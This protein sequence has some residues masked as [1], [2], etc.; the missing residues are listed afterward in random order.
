MPAMTSRNRLLPA[1]AITIGGILTAGAVTAMA[2]TLTAFRA[3]PQERRRAMPGDAIV[4]EEMYVTTQAATIAALPERVWP[5]LAQ[6]GADRGGWYSYD[7]VDNDGQPSARAILPEYQ[8][9]VPG[10]VFPAL[11]G[12]TDAFV[13]AAAQPPHELVL[14]GPAGGAPRVSWAF[15]LEPRPDG[16]T[17]LLVRAR[18]SP[19]WLDGT[20]NRTSVPHRRRLIERVYSVLPHLPAPLLHAAAGFG[21]RVMQNQQLRG[22]KR[23]AEAEP[24]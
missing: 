4:P 16:R 1:A 2:G 20:G 7:R 21:H 13:V 19:Q 17:R 24:G 6:M 3:S 12:A 18:V 23:R 11:P 10:D 8:H 15:L 9:V 14:T 22:I 5:W